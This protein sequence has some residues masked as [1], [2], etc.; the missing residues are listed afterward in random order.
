MD[1]EQISGILATLAA[2]LVTMALDT[3]VVQ[4][5]WRE[6]LSDGRHNDL[7]S[8]DGYL[9][10]A[11][12]MSTKIAKAISEHEKSLRESV[13][14]AKALD[15]MERRRAARAAEEFRYMPQMLV[16]DGRSGRQS[17]DFP[18]NDE[19]PELAEDEAF[20]AGDLVYIIGVNEV[21]SEHTRL[22][23]TDIATVK[24]KTFRV[25]KEIA[26][27]YGEEMELVRIE[28]PKLN[29]VKAY[30]YHSH[31][32]KLVAY[33]ME[34]QALQKLLY[35]PRGTRSEEDAEWIVQVWNRL[36]LGLKND[37]KG[38]AAIGRYLDKWGFF[39]NELIYTP[40]G[41]QRRRIAGN[42]AQAQKT[43]DDGQEPDSGPEI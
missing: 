2:K 13:D 22:L 32:L 39:D 7:R 30:I 35:P 27:R 16:L 10:A 29:G 20:Q 41:L 4:E 40:D 34:E 3:E 37:K 5:K 25:L 14:A 26:R 17:I 23:D 9:Y 19:H 43:Q 18:I 8:R 12:S 21:S 24:K 42:A 38:M 1:V 31:V 36:K 33:Y 11:R 15:D 28:G 6:V